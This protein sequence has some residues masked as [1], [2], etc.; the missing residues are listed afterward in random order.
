MPRYRCQA[1]VV[2]R[3]ASIAMLALFPLAVFIS[4]AHVHDDAEHGTADTCAIC[5]LVS[6]AVSSVPDDAG[7]IRIDLHGTVEVPSPESSIPVQHFNGI[8]A[9]PRAPPQA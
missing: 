6:N 4:T 2:N 1:S 9:A 5:L 8:I 3:V 7:F